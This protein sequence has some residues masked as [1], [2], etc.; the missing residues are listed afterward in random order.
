MVNSSIRYG[1]STRKLAGAVRAQKISRYRC[2]VCGRQ[3]VKRISSSIWECRH[4]ST[5]YA[6]GAYSLTT[7]S[8][9]AARA[10]IKNLSVKA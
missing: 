7:P 4:C 5:V 10:V 1:A 2:E 3:D 6:G 8:G 9:E